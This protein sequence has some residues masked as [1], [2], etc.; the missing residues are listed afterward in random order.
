LIKL[1]NQYQ[2]DA[3]RTEI[4]DMRLEFLFQRAL[5]CY[6]EGN[7]Q[8]RNRMRRNMRLCMADIRKLSRPWREKREV[9]ILCKKYEWIALKYSVKRILKNE[10]C[11]RNSADL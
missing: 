3:V 6:M 9:R 10:E 5:T 4:I 2:S 8:I 7:T 11:K 1:Y